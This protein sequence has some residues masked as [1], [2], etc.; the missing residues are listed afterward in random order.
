M[1][2]IGID[3][4]GRGAWAG[5][6]LVAA[7]CLKKEDTC[8]SYVDSKKLTAKQRY[9]LN[10]QILKSRNLVRL[11]WVENNEIDKLGLSDAMRLAIKRSLRS[12]DVSNYEIIIDGNY[13][14]LKTS[15]SKAVIKAED[16]FPE[17]AAASIIAKCAR[18]NLMKKYSRVYTHY[19][20][21]NNMGYGTG[22]HTTGL[23]EFGISN[24]HRLSFKPVKEINLEY[25]KNR[26]NS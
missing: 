19:G 22:K 23:K 18:D 10:N 20:F 12:V 6:L 15:N 16:K 24:I 7:V 25:H 9:Q 21:E 1:N 4:V 14:Y 26:P 17:V 3:E 8:H 11:G 5:P 13:D 2:L